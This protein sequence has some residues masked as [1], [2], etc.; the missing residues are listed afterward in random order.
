MK[1]HKISTTLELQG[2]YFV[3]A[4]RPGLSA[5]DDIRDIQYV[6]IP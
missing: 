3:D 2:G 4:P 1:I 5:M 6:K